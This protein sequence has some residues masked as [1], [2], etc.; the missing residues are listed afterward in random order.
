MSSVAIH[1]AAHIVV[2][3]SVGVEIWGASIGTGPGAG[4]GAWHD[5][6]KCSDAQKAKI[7]LAGCLAAARVGEGDL[8]SSAS[9]LEKMGK[10]LENE[11]M[12]KSV[13]ARY[14]VEVNTILDEWWKSVTALATALDERKALTADACYTILQQTRPIEWTV[15]VV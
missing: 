1:E 14:I 9:D 10:S 4:G 6:I 2:A 8:A 13:L 3:N 15:V 7:C 11:L 5:P 12:A